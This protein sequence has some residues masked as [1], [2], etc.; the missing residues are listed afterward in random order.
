MATGRPVWAGHIRLSL[1]SL[2]V[3]LY[4]ATSSSARL[5]FN[6]IHAPSG[7]RVR[8]EKVVPGI[9]PVDAEDIVRGFPL[10]KNDYVVLSEEE[11]DSVKLEARKTLELVQFVDAC[12][13]EPIWFDRPYFVVPDG[14]LAQEAF[15]VVRDALRKAGKV[16]LGQFVMRQRAYVGALKPCGRGMIVETLRFEDEVRRAAPYFEAIAD[17]K[18]DTELLDLAGELIARKSAPFDAGRFHD[19]YTDALRD[20]IEA[21]RKAKGGTLELDG[22]DDGPGAGGEVIDLMAAL[23]KSLAGGKA[24]AP[25]RKPAAD[26]ADS[27]KTDS[28]KPAKTRKAAAKPAGRSRRS[29]GKAA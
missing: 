3:K 1:V 11:I 5:S 21:K 17:A 13:I 12:E 28:G 24:R 23:R 9:G 15:T 22:D 25:A 26:K 29:S 20:L 2:P 16:G 27:G 6:Q 18:A 7:K 19:Q 4:P 14:D 8:Y 10:G